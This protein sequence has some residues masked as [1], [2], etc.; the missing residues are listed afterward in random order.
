MKM[1]WN[2]KNFRNGKETRSSLVS[3]RLI[4]KIKNNETNN[5]NET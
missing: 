4:E 2:N 1:S 3:Q 5:L